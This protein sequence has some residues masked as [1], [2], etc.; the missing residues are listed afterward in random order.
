M[1]IAVN[2][3]LLLKNRLAGI[4]WF[5]YETLKRITRSH[6]E[7]EFI[8]IFDR[9]YDKEF[10]FSKNIKPIV[11]SP[12]TRHPLLYILWFECQIPSILRKHKADLFLSP[13]G[14][15]SL[16]TKKPQIGVIHDIN[17]A[18]R[19]QDLPW[20]YRKYYNHFFP[21]FAQKASRLATVSQYSKRDIAATYGIANEKIDV[22]YNGVNEMYTP[23]PDAQ[24]RVVQIHYSSSSPYFLFIG[25]FSARKNIAGLI[26][27]FDIFK[28]TDKQKFKL[29]LI[30][31]PLFRDSSLKKAFDNLA[32]KDD[33]VFLGRQTPDN[34][35][36]ILASAYALA[37]VPLFEGF[38]IPVAEAI[39]C[40][41]PL[42]CSNT[43]SIPEVAGQ[44]AIMVDPED[45]KQIASA[46]TE[47]ST[48]E[49]RYQQ[50][51]EATKQQSGTFTWQKSA[52]RLWNTIE[53][54]LK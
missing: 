46:M 17:F 26:K 23:L 32:H 16:R 37:F 3:R 22:V 18:H 41:V 48:N 4:G 49:R 25:A 9:A 19:P 15:L 54:G 43:T 10:I 24:K 47:I 14:F 5:T 42:I 8:F 34:L 29:L 36:Q 39:Q 51:I 11:V 12:P 45:T 52:D 30:G 20:S 2:V 35:H 53:K 31:E 1:R 40:H 6:P 50:L 21:K 27:A 44:A 38:G 7:H 13:D 28:R 33:I